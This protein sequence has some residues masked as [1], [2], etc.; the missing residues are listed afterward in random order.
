LTGTVTSCETNSSSI[1]VYLK[2]LEKSSP[3]PRAYFVK[4]QKMAVAKLRNGQRIEF[5]GTITK[6]NRDVFIIVNCELL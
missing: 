5:M 6:L 1:S 2:K 4:S 3:V